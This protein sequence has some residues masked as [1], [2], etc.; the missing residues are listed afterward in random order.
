MT[1]WETFVQTQL[2]DGVAKTRAIG[3]SGVG[4]YGDLAREYQALEEGPAL[5]DRS[6]RGLLEI[7]GRDRIG[8]LHN[9]TT[10]DVKSLAPGQGRYAFALNR[11]GRILFD[12]NILARQEVVQI[13]IDRRWVSMAQAHF[14]KYVIM[15]DV[16]IV[17]RSAEF[18]RLGWGGAMAGAVLAQWSAPDV[19]KVPSLGTFQVVWNGLSMPAMRHDFCGTLAVEILVPAARAVEFWYRWSDP[20]GSL[21]AVPVGD[22][23]VQVR[24]I[25]AG[26]PWPFHEMTDEYLPAETGQLDRAVSFTKGCY[27]GQEIVGRMRSRG[28]IARRLVGLHVEGDS[29][30]PPGASLTHD[31]KPVGQLT[32]ACRSLATGRVIGLG[33]VK[34]QFTD[35]GN[36]LTLAYK[37]TQL[38]ALV[39]ELPFA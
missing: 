2:D 21:R 27:L 19:H 3:W 7:T 24:R 23:A 10:N 38:P 1:G 13:D 37:D 17:D 18:V 9:L 25:E 22:D 26:I 31:G 14:E 11:Q 30:P 8:W 4:T 20:G 16:H 33:Y 5:V 35:P 34:T 32:S 6:Y 12:L 36:S 39:A 15:E 28:A 29:V